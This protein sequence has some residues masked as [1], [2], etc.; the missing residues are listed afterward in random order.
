MYLDMYAASAQLP[1]FAAKYMFWN[2]SPTSRIGIANF[3][4]A[5]SHLV[6]LLLHLLGILRARHVGH[7]Q[8]QAGPAQRNRSFS[9]A[10]LAPPMQ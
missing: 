8:Q 10:H 2:R 3:G 6:D 7:R 9:H 1:P 4:S 5:D